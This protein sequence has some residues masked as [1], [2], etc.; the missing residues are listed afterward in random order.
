[1][2]A[3]TQPAPQLETINQRLETFMRNMLAESDIPKMYHGPILNLAKGYFLKASEADARKILIEIQEQVIPWL[4]NGG[5]PNQN[6][7]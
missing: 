3:Q 7:Q 6:P 5:N 4:L 1:M 2:A